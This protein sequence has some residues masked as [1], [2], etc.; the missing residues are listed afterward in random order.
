MEHKDELLTDDIEK[1]LSSS[2]APNDIRKV[3]YGLLLDD[4]E[5]RGYGK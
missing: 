4:S 5:L 3:V 1:L 2:V